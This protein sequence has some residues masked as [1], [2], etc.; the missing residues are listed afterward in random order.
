MSVLDYIVARFRVRSPNIAAAFDEVQRRLAALEAPA[1]RTPPPIAILKPPA[2][3][4]N[5]IA[6]ADG[7]LDPLW[8][9]DGRHTAGKGYIGVQAD[10]LG[11]GGPVTR[12]TV[13]DGDVLMGG[14]RCETMTR[15]I[16]GP[17]GT[18]LQVRF[19]LL[20]PTGFRS[21]AGGWNSLW[22]LHYPTDGPAQSPITA[23]IRYGDELWYRVLGG[24]LTVDGTMG[25]VRYEGMVARLAQG[26]WHTICHD[27][28]LDVS[29]GRLDV[30]VD[31][32]RV[33][34]AAWSSIP[35]ISSSSGKPNTVYWK[36]GFYRPP[37]SGLGTQTY[38][39][40]DTLC[41]R[42]SGPEAMLA[43]PGGGR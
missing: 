30:W 14:E 10:P 3:R 20:L 24:P 6:V 19:D 12:Y 16:G 38:F 41:W 35:T 5:Y 39:F 18:R 28:L 43:W 32:M 21:G 15:Q 33:S 34:P 13:D 7:Q 27:V 17:P 4:T 37:G 25:S 9:P 42:E 31:G 1:P 8:Q 36:Q 22:D 26:V 40:G 2:V 23:S 29:A 11:S